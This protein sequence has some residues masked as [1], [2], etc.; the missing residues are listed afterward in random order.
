MKKTK[1]GCPHDVESWTTST[2]EVM[3]LQRAPQFVF[4]QYSGNVRCRNRSILEKNNSDQTSQ[5]KSDAMPAFAHWMCVMARLCSS[6][7]WNE[8]KWG[9]SGGGGRGFL[10]CSFGNSKV[11]NVF[12]LP[13]V[14]NLMWQRGVQS[15][16]SA[17][18]Y[19]EWMSATL[20]T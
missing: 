6:N 15:V 5:C 2:V 14:P 18:N 12:T 20:Y 19:F 4:W 11:P 7:W 10:K 8:R 9:S 16:T 13:F 17:T 1:A 3:C